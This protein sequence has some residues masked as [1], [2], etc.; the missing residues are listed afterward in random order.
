MQDFTAY[1]KKQF[2]QRW[3]RQVYTVC[4]GTNKAKTQFTIKVCI[5]I[6]NPIT[7]GGK[8]VRSRQVQNISRMVADLCDLRFDREAN[9]VIFGG[10]GLDVGEAIVR[11][12]STKLYGDAYALAQHWL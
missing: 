11:R 6:N 7:L 5:A 9:S 4:V 8:T 10:S 3:N 12:L 1:L 2:K